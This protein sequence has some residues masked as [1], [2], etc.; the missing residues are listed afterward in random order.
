LIGFTHDPRTLGEIAMAH[1]SSLP[2]QGP[3]D[4]DVVLTRTNDAPHLY[5]ISA[6]GKAPQI[7]FTSFEEAITRADAFAQVHNVDVWHTDDGHV[8]TR[9][10]EGRAV[11]SV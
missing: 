4:G 5:T 9:I 11:G 2:G 8:F 10:V 7:A 1:S 6:M 3:Q